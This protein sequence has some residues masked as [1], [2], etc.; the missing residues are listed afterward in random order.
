MPLELIAEALFRAKL[1]PSNSSVA[2]AATMNAP[3]SVPP[4]VRLKVPA[5]TLTVPVLWLLKTVETVV[6]LAPEATV[7]SN[8][9]ALSKIP[10]PV[11]WMIS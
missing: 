11:Y 1:P 7:L 5:S 10:V 2:P 8:S 6:V 9:P 3:V 4:P